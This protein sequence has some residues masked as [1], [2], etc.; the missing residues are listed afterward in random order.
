MYLIFR[1]ISPFKTFKTR[2]SGIPSGHVKQIIATSY[3]I[4]NHTLIEHC[5][6]PNIELRRLAWK[7]MF[8]MAEELIALDYHSVQYKKYI[9]NSN[10]VVMLSN[11]ISA[12]W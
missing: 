12:P 3:N 10:N 5:T 7:K 9:R 11:F 1:T 8:L 4:K 6:V 2:L